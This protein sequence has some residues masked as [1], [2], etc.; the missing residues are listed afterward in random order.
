MVAHPGWRPYPEPATLEEFKRLLVIRLETIEDATC[1][2]TGGKPLPV[3]WR[4]EWSCKLTIIGR[5]PDGSLAAKIVVRSPQLRCP[6]VR[7]VRLVR[8]KRLNLRYR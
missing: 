2:V 6:Y 1:L 5:C 3:S 4:S 7:R 8:D